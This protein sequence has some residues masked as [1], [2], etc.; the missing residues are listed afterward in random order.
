MHTGRRKLAAL[1]S[2]VSDIICERLSA[3]YGIGLQAGSTA[4]EA[5]TAVAVAV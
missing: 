2:D 4:S 5:D 3:R 1:L